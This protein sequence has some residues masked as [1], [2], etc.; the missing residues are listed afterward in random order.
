[1]AEAVGGDRDAEKVAPAQPETRLEPG[2]NGSSAAP[3]TATA[4][5]TATGAEQEPFFRQSPRDVVKNQRRFGVAY[6]VLAIAVG[7][8]VGF[9]IVLVGRGSSH[10]TSG[11]SGFTPQLQGE[12]GAKEI[13]N[14]VMHEYKLPTGQDFVGVV[15][16]RPSF[17]NVAMHDDLVRPS[18]AQT[19]KDT[20]ILPIGNGIMYLMCG[21]G[22]SCTINEPG[23]A[24]A[25]RTHLV[26]QEALELTLRTFKNDS[27]VKTVTV[28]M[29][30]VS[31]DQ[32]SGSDVVSF[33][34]RSDFQALIDKPLSSVINRAGPYREGDV[35]GTTVQA[36][37]NYLEPDMYTYRPDY[38]PDGTPT[39]IMDPYQH[40]V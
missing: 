35:S 40:G 5:A 37:K 13:A 24:T 22:Q 27:G 26:E 38:L 2:T 7:V 30:P 28:L 31:T 32:S 39:L 16:Q 17:Q 20:T 6:I 29:P 9:G 21:D 3:A 34:V 25:A 14:H 12:L 4:T 33:A 8:A 36:I 11:P 19:P 15:G 23:A 1:V 18:D 10:S